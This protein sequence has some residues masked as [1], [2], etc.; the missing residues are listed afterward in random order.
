MNKEKVDEKKHPLQKYLE[1]QGY[2]IRY[3]HYRFLEYP[4][5]VGTAI[6]INELKRKH[7]RGSGKIYNFGGKTECVILKNNE[8][9]AV[10]TAICSLEDNYCK[11]EGRK[12]ALLRAY[13][14]LA[15][16]CMKCGVSLPD[17][18]PGSICEDCENLKDL[19]GMSIAHILQGL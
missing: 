7:E 14:K 13:R 5:D 2:L 9:L 17:E 12:Y 1:K 18:P 11:A 6:V 16:K 3:R 4:T 10:G 19:R 8:E 15:K